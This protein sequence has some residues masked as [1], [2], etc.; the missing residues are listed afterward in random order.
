MAVVLTHYVY[1]FMQTYWNFESYHFQFYIENH[2]FII[3]VHKKH[4]LWAT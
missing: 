4:I 2:T 1:D 3:C